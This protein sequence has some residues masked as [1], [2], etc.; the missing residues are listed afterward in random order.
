MSLL[1]FQQYNPSKRTKNLT[2]ALDLA[3]ETPGPSFCEEE[4]SEPGHEDEIVESLSEQAELSFEVMKEPNQPV[5][6]DFP[7]KSFG[8]KKIEFRTFRFALFHDPR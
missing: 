5:S 1:D 3:S 7:K 6:F 8:K 2:V 4:S